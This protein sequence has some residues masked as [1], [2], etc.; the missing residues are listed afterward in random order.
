MFSK[1]RKDIRNSWCTID[2]NDTGGKLTTG[3]VDTRSRIF[4]EIYIDRSDNG[5][6]MPPV[7]T[8]PAV[9]LPHVSTTLVVNNDSSI[10]LP[11]S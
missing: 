11:T 6:N 8:K 5:V 1:I 3:V 9:H 7:S 2:V 10:R 4:F